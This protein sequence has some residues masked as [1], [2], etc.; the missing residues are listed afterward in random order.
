MK[1]SLVCWLCAAVLSADAAFDEV[2]A[3]R[4]PDADAVL[5]D[6]L[7]RVEY[8]PD[9]TSETW[10]ESWTKIL[11]EKGR[12]EES[13]TSLDYSKRYGMGEIVYVG[14]IGADGQERAVDVS[15]TTKESTDNASMASN[16]YDPLDR[17]IVCRIPGLKV[18]DVVHLKTHRKTFKPRTEGKWADLSVMEWSCPIVRSRYEVKAPASLP[19]RRKA[20]RH[21][22]GNV[23]ASERKLDD[24]SVLHTFVATNSP[25]AFPE[26]V[27]PPLYTQVQCVRLS[28]AESWQDISRWYWD[29]CQGHLAKTNAAMVAKVNELG[30]DMRALFKFVSQEI[31]YMGLTM[32]DTSPGYA[33][34]D[35]DVTFDNRYGVCRDKAGLLV[36]MLRLAG[37]RAFPVLIHVGAKLDPEVPQP[38]FNHAIVAVEQ[39]NNPNNRTIEQYL[40]MDPTNEN[41]KDLFP[42]YLGNNSYLVCRPEGEDLRVSPVAPA[43]E[44]AVGVVSK[45][46][47]SKDGSV[48]LE[49]DIRFGGVN[50]TVYRGAFARRKPEDRAKFFEKLLKAISPSAELVKCEIEPLDMR[51][52]ERALT[53][54]LVSKL[55]EMVLEGERRDELAVPLVSKGLG[56]VNFLL[57]GNTSLEKRKYPLVLDTTASVR[58]T[59]ALDFAAALGQVQTLPPDLRLDGGH[60]YARTFAV[61]G[62]TLTVSRTMAVDAVEFDPAGYQAIRENI[63][64]IEAA[65]RR[66]PTF[67]RDALKEADVRVLLDRVETT[68]FSDR[69]W[70][71]TNTLVKEVLTY[72][73]KKKSAELKL[74]FNPTWKR[75]EVLSA[76]VSNRNGKVSVV[77]PKEMNVMD[78]GWA[79]SA[80]RYPAGKILVV[81]LPSVEIGSVIS[82]Q[83]VTTVSNAPSAFYA[84]YS[85]DTFEPVDRR[86]VRVDD[87]SREAKD[88]KRLPNE[89]GQ[90]DGSLWRDQV[91]VS[92][93]AFEPIELCLAELDPAEI[94]L[95]NVTN[96]VEIRDWMA[97][98][99]K[100]AGPAMYDVPL[101]RQLTEPS[102]V[103]KERY[104][105]RLDYVRTLCALLRG[106]GCDA[107]V[108]L[109]NPNADEPEAI[110]RRERCEKPNVRAFATALCRVRETTGGFLG[111]GGETR[112]LYLGTESEYAPLGA[113]A[114][115]G[116]DFFDPVTGE[117]GVVPEPAEELRPY[118]CETDEFVVRENGAVDLTVENVQHGPGVAAFRRKYAEIL[119]EDRSRLHQKILGAVAQAASA[120]SELEADF[121][122]YP[123]RRKFS[124]FIPDYAT[125]DG[126]TITLQLPPF[127]SPLP[128]YTGTLRRSPF[129][130]DAV[131]KSCEKVVVKFPE[132]FTEIEHL[133]QEFTFADPADARRP[134]L[135]AK[136]TQSVKDGVLT[137][138]IVRDT[139]KRPDAWYGPETFEL[140]RDW[141]RIASSRANRTIVVRRPINR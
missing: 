48:V 128:A 123:A 65:E 12:R 40:L 71:T 11:T 100:V 108:V 8:K 23:V 27:M 50:D 114:Y 88:L 38:F 67:A 76:S 89:P 63:K 139:F 87:W 137:V 18:G 69:S 5:V 81:S 46:R 41:T 135:T 92:R 61:T 120:T 1:T 132:G 55:P 78:C 73:G 84:T 60:A 104:A 9:G 111:F 17:K 34:H 13:S 24:G 122:G 124:C 6:E 140:V 80:P 62:G 113:T 72:A 51:D 112:E 97:K 134:W 70:V 91:I 26:P 53:V 36:A 83:T 14:A 64:R 115:S 121:T 126:E 95:A 32:E 85:F 31:R 21:P 82:V 57:E 130:V 45:G 75:V 90:P 28:T 94:G 42:A 103:V 102:V 129:A 86:V 133:P 107:D 109:V 116:S 56:Y 79:A 49:N 29:L 22:L 10:A 99:V 3:E 30:R 58:E 7:E 101:A 20:V 138:E 66:R 43:T 59:L 33:P 44:N 119:P 106:A 105:T 19:I 4:Y 141:R 37:F 77:S 68:T 117:F 35:V 16:I 96:L 2:T 131:E 136:V 118:D 98:H 15:K 39:S 74:N 47:V 125:V 110:R 54:K 93:C 25:Q 52:T 127:V